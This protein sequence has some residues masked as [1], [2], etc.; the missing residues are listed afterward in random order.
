M[1]KA[2]TGSI[3]GKQNPMHG[4]V[5]LALGACLGAL[6]LPALAQA[7][8]KDEIVDGPYPLCS[9]DTD[10]KS[11]AEGGQVL[12]L[13]PMGDGTYLVH[14]VDAVDAK[15]CVKS[16]AAN[17]SF[18][19]EGTAPA[20]IAD[21]NPSGSPIVYDFSTP[22]FALK[23]RVTE[24][25]ICHGYYPGTDK[26]A[27]N[28]ADTNGTVHVLRG[29]DT[30]DYQ[31]GNGVLVPNFAAAAHGAYARCHVF[32]YGTTIAN[33]PTQ[34]SP[35]ASNILFGAGFEST[36]DLEVLFFADDGSNDPMVT[37]LVQAYPNTNFS[38]RVRVRNLGDAQ[39]H[40]VSV[41]EFLPAASGTV[42]PAVSAVACTGDETCSGP[43]D[44][45][46]GDLNARDERWF[47]L[48]RAIPSGTVG[49]RTVLA[50]AA[51]S[52][53]QEASDPNPANNARALVAEVVSNQSPA[54]VCDDLTATVALEENDNA[55]TYICTVTDLED[56]I[57]GF[58]ATSSNNTVLA[59]ST[60]HVSGDDWELE[61][62]PQPNQ[63]GTGITVTLTATASAGPSGN[64][65]FAVNV[66]QFNDPPEFDLL[67]SDIEMNPGGG[68][69]YD[70]ENAVWLDAPD[71]VYGS[72]CTNGADTTCKLTFPDFLKNASVGLPPE[73][74]G[75]QLQAAISCSPHTG[76]GIG[77]FSSAPAISPAGAQN[78]NQ[79]FVLEL[80]YR[81]S[82]FPPPAPNLG[83]EVVCQVT[84][85]D[86]GVPAKSL[87]KTVKFSFYQQ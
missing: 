74:A 59:V 85:T 25:V 9:G 53:P 12:G 29:M 55:V 7:A 4:S 41:R 11:L 6:A 72:N 40:N 21:S 36:G 31:L 42:A 1:M 78:A 38:Y 65:V 69:S 76:G 81:K 47:T 67:S 43:L 49:A 32:P 56:T 19:F 37:N 66:A 82:N 30:V 17:L 62:T 16:T 57:T 87:S 63:S 64:H 45:F 86:T 34:S 75:Q 73:S 35:T 79:P 44:V 22:P 70:A 2:A 77:P 14:T 84:V 58:T 68:L 26:L 50:V 51:F 20:S 46:L 83:A 52:D 5:L 24:P 39:A 71:V 15:S 80:T 28:L 61:L 18:Q 13:Y 48:T 8:S 60:S 3:R 33:P 23:A 10:V 54:I 27:L